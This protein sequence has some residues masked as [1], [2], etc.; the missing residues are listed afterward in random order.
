[1]DAFRIDEAIAEERVQMGSA[2]LA[3]EHE[4]GER[5]EPSAF[6]CTESNGIRVDS[7]ERAGKQDNMPQQ[8]RLTARSLS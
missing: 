4:R 3:W 1:V 8:F 6:D 7:F 5:R 2:G